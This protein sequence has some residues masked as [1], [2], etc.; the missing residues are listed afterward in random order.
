MDKFS[1]ADALTYLDPDGATL[2][3]VRARRLTPS[4]QQTGHSDTHDDTLTILR[5]R[6]YV[7]SL[8]PAIQGQNG[9]AAA[10][11]AAVALVHGFCLSADDAFSIFS[12][13]YNPTCLP[14][15]SDREIWHKLND[16]ATQ[17]HNNPRGYLRGAAV[18]GQEEVSEAHEK[19]Q[20]RAHNM[21][22][23]QQPQQHYREQL[24]EEDD[25]PLRISRWILSQFKHNDLPTLIYWGGDWWEWS[26]FTWSKNDDAE[27]R[28]MIHNQSARHLE[29]VQQTALRAIRDS[30]SD[31]E[32][33]PKLKKTTT[34]LIANVEL[35]L[36]SVT[37][38]RR[39]FTSPTWL[40]FATDQQK[41]TDPRD[42]IP[43]KN[44][45]FNLPK[46]ASSLS[47]PSLADSEELSQP[48]TPAFFSS[49][50]VDYSIDLAADKPKSWLEFL[51][52]IWPGDTESID[53][54]QEWFGYLLSGETNQQ[55]LFYLVGPPRSGKGTISRVLQRLVGVDNCVA[56][57]IEEI[58]DQFGLE[59]ML[60][61]SI[62]VFEDV[63]I[64][65]RDD[66]GRI[67]SWLKRL[68]G[69]DLIS[70]RRK[71]KSTLSVTNTARLFMT[72]NEIPRL[73]DASMAMA[74]R[75]SY[76]VCEHSHLGREDT[77]LTNR[78]LT[79]LPGI[80][81]WS[82]QGWARLKAAGKFTMPASTIRVH[83]MTRE[84]GSPISQFVR[85]KCALNPAY[86]VNVDELYSAWKEW[87]EEEGIRCGSRDSFGR[88]LFACCPSVQKSR[89]RS[90][91]GRMYV[92]RGLQLSSDTE[93]VD[94]QKDMFGQQELPK[95]NKRTYF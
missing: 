84:L 76:L 43:A 78:L 85:T 59:S 63:F 58:G 2:A 64:S 34:T 20:D 5:A 29:Q 91:D 53:L 57:S 73:P 28:A 41:K 47:A 60:G 10:Y 7:A 93:D 16:A 52:S 11:A 40:E 61:K 89:I 15:W 90:S 95:T 83:E 86:S 25:D 12:E 18:V 36:K 62:A 72:S 27:M 75:F 39:D 4:G 77:S 21:K 31:A 24:N 14:P 19:A 65:T 32:R 38:N 81:L 79:E 42:L 9:S 71:Y 70:V 22:Q 80:F 82:V 50:A 3:F 74:N 88:L 49:A 67:G 48:C 17:A 46:I 54:L 30:K 1:L 94:D 56:C 45:L 66:S 37:Y 51:S 13:V 44:G 68:I 8:P 33:L 87:C 23:S 26:A 35:A 55:K 69:Q 92:Y 6:R